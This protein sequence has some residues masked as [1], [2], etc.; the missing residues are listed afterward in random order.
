[1]ERA[2]QGSGHSPEL[3]EL[4]KHLNI[5]LRHRVWILGGA[6][7]SWELDLTILVGPL[8][9]RIFYECLLTFFS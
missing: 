9:L 3:L 6:V 8:Q 5:S 2:A 4:E 7:G 1:M